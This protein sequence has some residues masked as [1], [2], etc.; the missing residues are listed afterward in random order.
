MHWK[1]LFAPLTHMDTK[2]VE[3]FVESQPEGTYTLLDGRQPG[4]YEKILCQIADEEKARLLS[5]GS[6]LEQKI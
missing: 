6:M 1:D 3:S 4:A 2:Q 5:L